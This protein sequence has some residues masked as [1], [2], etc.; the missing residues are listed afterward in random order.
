MLGHIKG[1]VHGTWDR[2]VVVDVNGLG[3]EVQ[4]PS[5]LLGKIPGKGEKVFLHTHLIWKEDSISLYGFLDPSSRELFRMLL[6]VSGVG[7]RLALTILSHL[8]PGTLLAALASG[9]KERLQAIHGIGK[10]TAARLCVDL[11]ERAARLMA[12]S[13][14]GLKGEA[15]SRSIPP[16]ASDMVEQAVS[17]L[18]NL[19]YR[20]PEARSAVKRA[21]TTMDGDGSI[22]ELIT[23]GLKALGR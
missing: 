21:L 5:S 6:E 13:Q 22:E 19:G 3:Y 1:R 18:V 17:A 23:E 12:A 7:P 11:K 8:D 15:A 10:K 2:G 4:L 16:G 9:S 20:E 14:G